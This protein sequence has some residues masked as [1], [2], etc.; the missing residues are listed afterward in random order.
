MS[1]VLPA[2]KPVAYQ[3][4]T[5]SEKV[6]TVNR[7]YL[8]GMIG[9]LLIIAAMA[10]QM[11]RLSNSVAHMRPWIVRVDQVGN[12]EA[13][14]V[15]EQRFVPQEKELKYFVRRF[16]E[17]YFTRDRATV[18][19]TYPLAGYLMT[20][21]FFSEQQAN[22]AKSKWLEKF[23]ASQDENQDV[24]VKNVASVQQIGHNEYQ[25]L[26]YF[27]KVFVGAGGV[28]VK[29]EK[30]IE[31][32]RFVL[33]GSLVTPELIPYNPLGLFVEHVKVDPAFE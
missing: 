23:L 4:L 6:Q 5:F 19:K 7:L 1:A 9:A 22:D 25:A 2:P 8:L 28:Q 21:A 15:N 27:D 11:V 16:T 31:T 20:P 33:D 18:A 3:E 14:N 29:R 17:L 30:D 10:W 13:V 26:V 24:D 12:A 32:L